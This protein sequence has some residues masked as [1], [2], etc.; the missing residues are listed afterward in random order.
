MK[1]AGIILFLFG[2]L[3]MAIGVVV[4]IVTLTDDYASSACTRAAIDAPKFSEARARCGSP[5]TE[6][7]RQATVGLITQDECDS[8]R[9]FMNR[10][11][12]MG[13]VPAVIGGLLAFIG[14]LLAVF[15]FVRT[16]RKRVN[17]R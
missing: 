17:I 10:Q 7:Y 4:C 14:L 2:G 9:A 6:C 15:G 13:I 16:R 3:V 5:S 8:R 11:L 1:I 12:I